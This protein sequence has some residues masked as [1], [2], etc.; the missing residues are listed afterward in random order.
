[1]QEELYKEFGI[2]DNELK[3]VIISS[4]LKKIDL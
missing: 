3:E 2:I 4:S 1:M